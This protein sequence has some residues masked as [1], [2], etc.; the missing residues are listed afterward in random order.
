[1]EGINPDNEQFYEQNPEVLAA[2]EGLRKLKAQYGRNLALRDVRDLL[3]D[4]S[5]EGPSLIIDLNDDPTEEP[6]VQ[7]RDVSVLELGQ[8]LAALATIEAQQDQ[9]PSDTTEERGEV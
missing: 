4:E 6:G 8:R 1:M 9:D 3:I 2:L 7:Q 5:D